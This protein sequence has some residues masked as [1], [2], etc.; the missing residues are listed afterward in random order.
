VVVA[1]LGMLAVG[2]VVVNRL[3]GRTAFSRPDDVGV[4]E[5]V[6]FVV[7]PA[8]P[9]VVF[10]SARA[11]VYVVLF[12]LAVL[13]LSYAA[14]GFG[15]L[16]MV[17]FGA[18]QMWLRVAEMGILLARALPLLLLFSVVIFV[19]AEMWQIS[20]DVPPVFYAVFVVT[21]LLVVVGFLALRAPREVASLEHFDTWEQV[22]VRARRTDAPIADAP[23]A[24]HGAA[25]VEVPELDRAER[26]NVALLVVIAQAV[27]VVMVGLTIGLFY[28]GFGL[29]MVRGET[30]AQWT[31]TPRD[32]IATFDLLGSEVVV[33]W[34]L[35]AMSGIIASFAALQFGVAMLTDVTY[36]DEF[37]E[38]VTGEIRD[39]L[40]VR[41]LY[42]D[43][44]VE[45]DPAMPTG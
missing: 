19:N 44:L 42:Y 10:V 12:N 6:L 45:T 20:S 43:Q 37:Y 16:S 17:R 4:L 8:V 15:L 2:V 34:E 7:A 24:H 29:L 35:F 38:H 36:R 9:T 22:G 41:A 11:A 18:K 13:A 40:A 28:V 26:I 1:A 31:V 3:R 14:V 33:T 30:L 5:L 32:A 27:Q 25:A 23:V 21:F 39:I